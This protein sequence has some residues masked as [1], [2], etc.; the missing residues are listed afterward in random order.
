MSRLRAKVG[1]SV[2]RH[3]LSRRAP[4]GEV[5]LP[6]HELISPLRLDVLVRVEMFRTIEEH[7]GATDAELLDLV[8]GGD[9]ET[10]FRS[11][12]MKRYEPGV[13]ADDR[14]FDTEFAARVSRTIALW[15]SFRAHGFD[16]R[17][18]ITLRRPGPRT[19]LP[20]GKPV[21]RERYLGDGCHRL[22]MMV[23][24]GSR[25]VPAGRYRIEPVAVPEVLDNTSLLLP[26][27]QPSEER[28]A[29]FI[30]WGYEVPPA[31]AVADVLDAIRQRRPARFGEA[32]A[33]V[34]ADGYLTPT[35]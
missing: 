8:R 18:P 21:Q 26:L 1:A 33:V 16:Q 10:W 12:A 30:A 23:A 11:V 22:A 9:Y 2:R 35:R 3:T 4:L 34:A 5:D 7:A 14:R 6:V 32:S 25:V 24:S 15:R 17:H 13:A 28:Y 19:R 27:L 31:D 20:D 29:R